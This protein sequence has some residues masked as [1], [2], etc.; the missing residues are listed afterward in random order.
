[1]YYEFGVEGTPCEVSRTR[2]DNVIKR[3]ITR[4]KPLT[5]AVNG[6]S[7]RL[8]L[9][10]LSLPFFSHKFSPCFI[11]LLR[12][13]PP[14]SF[15]LPQ[16]PSF[17]VVFNLRVS[18]YKLLV[19]PKGADITALDL[20]FADLASFFTQRDTPDRIH[21]IQDGRGRYSR[22]GRFLRHVRSRRRPVPQ[23]RQRDGRYTTAGKWHNW[24]CLLGQQDPTSQEGRWH[25]AVA[26]GYPIPVPQ[27]CL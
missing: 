21:L 20:R 26:Q 11:F 22:D 13:P 6:V 24:L 27:A 8:A 9:P 19:P 18:R 17:I 2:V 5:F 10:V 12:L 23:H 25:S 16:S 14:P 1:M 3:N 7:A 4:H 15:S